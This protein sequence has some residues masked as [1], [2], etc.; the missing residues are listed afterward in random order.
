MFSERV[1]FA[2]LGLSS[3]L[4]F[5]F[6]AS[7][8][9]DVVETMNSKLVIF[10][11]LTNPNPGS[12][13]KNFLYK[14]ML[15]TGPTTDDNQIYCDLQRME[16]GQVSHTL[17]DR[18]VINNP[19]NWLHFGFMFGSGILYYADD[20]NIGVK[21]YE[22]IFLA[23]GPESRRSKTTSFEEER[24][25]DT[26]YEPNRPME[27]VIS[28]SIANY[29]NGDILT[30]DDMFGVRLHMTDANLGAIPPHSIFSIEE[31]LYDK[32]CIIHSSQ[33]NWCIIHAFLWNMND[34]KESEF[35]FHRYK[36]ISKKNCKPADCRL[37]F[38]TDNCLVPMSDDYNQRLSITNFKSKRLPLRKITEFDG[39]SE[40]AIGLRNSHIKFENHL[41]KVYWIECP[42]ECNHA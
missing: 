15:R 22:T 36:Y 21:T 4:T 41:G 12:K 2:D 38:Q 26:F 13:L 8:I 7:R 23:N 27:M 29:Q 9:E 16:N 19:S 1:I 5:Q 33:K 31:D 18:I 37:C 28:I 35:F 32:R 42:P 6:Y 25:L 39:D 3:S 11:T 40:E 10:I 24:S 20:E 34:K 30:E 17:S 14:L